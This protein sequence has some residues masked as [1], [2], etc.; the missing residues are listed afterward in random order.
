MPA[1]LV[2][3]YDA[4]YLPGTCAV[5]ICNN[6]ADYTA[7]TDTELSDGIN[8]TRQTRAIEGWSQEGEQVPRPDFAS[9][10][11]SSIP[12]R[13]TAADSSLA[14][15]AK[16]NGA[17]V[18]AQLTLGW[19]GYVV[20]MPGGWVTGYRM[21]VFPVTVRSKPKQYNDSDPFNILYQFSIRQP[22]AEDLVIPAP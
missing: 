20:L 21:D 12:G 15:Y 11:T 9:L 3:A 5:I 4:F 6:F 2:E 14:I 16:K 10:F 1:P 7:P 8:V 17:D 13:L 22:P 18:R 19:A